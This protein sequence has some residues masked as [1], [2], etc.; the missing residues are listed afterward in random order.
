MI[1]GL[2]VHIP[3]C[4]SRCHYCHFTSIENP[5]P[6]LR[7]RYL[8]AF[9]K[10]I[11][12]AGEAYGPLEFETL[13]FGGGTPSLLQA[14]EITRLLDILKKYFKIRDNAEVT[15]EWN[16]EDRDEDRL[17][18]L[19]RLGVNRISLGAQSFEDRLLKKLGRRHS[20]R[21]TVRALEKIRKSG[22]PNISLDLM[23][24]LPGQTPEHFRHSLARCVELK[25]SQV[26]LYDLEVHEDTEFGR[27]R[28]KGTL[29]LPS[30]EEHAEM[31]AS[32]ID[33]L[34]RAGYEHYEISNFS[35]PGFASRHN[36]IYWHNQ[37]YLGLGPG[38]FSYLGGIRY[39]FALTADRYLQ[40]CEAGVWTNDTQ[41]V[42]SFPD[43]V[44]ETFVTG[45]RLKEGVPMNGLGNIF[46]GM[47][48]RIDFLSKEGFLEIAGG[49]I[50]LTL[51]GQC[52]CE[53]VFRHL[54]QKTEGSALPRPESALDNIGRM[55]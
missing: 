5:S 19:V 15:C 35:I 55:L 42:L 17:A 7:T 49:N 29:V 34:T 3:F 16:P 23:L 30:E 39:Q 40:K 48:E 28:T 53:E 41:D 54:L 50:C 38:A 51:H 26:A 20:S 10:E 13:Y 27:R 12:H 43:K 25:A 2:Y 8:E 24:R 21:D 18:T 47:R 33:I 44:I 32:A 14:D 22:I 6:E 36:L 37:E 1:K 52:L 46:P 4:R 45:L 9:F 31:Y 11:R